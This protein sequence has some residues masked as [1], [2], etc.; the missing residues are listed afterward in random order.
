MQQW[1]RK[2]SVY[3]QWMNVCGGEHYWDPS[4][5]CPNRLQDYRYKQKTK[6][7]VL[8]DTKSH[9][10]LENILEC[11]LCFIAGQLASL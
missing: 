7:K 9:E 10:Q 6:Q 3:L 5:V 8:P 2:F 11:L 1:H 4:F